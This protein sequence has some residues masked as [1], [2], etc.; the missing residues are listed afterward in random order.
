MMELGG[1]KISLLDT[2]ILT[3]LRVVPV[4]LLAALAVDQLNDS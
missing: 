4:R 3:P 1:S 2:L